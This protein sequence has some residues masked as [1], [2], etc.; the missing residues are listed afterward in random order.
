MSYED[1]QSQLESGDHD[2]YFDDRE[3]ALA[4]MLDVHPEELSAETYGGLYGEGETYTVDG[5]EY[6]VLT[7][8]ETESAV[9]EALD[10]YLDDCILCELPEIAQQYFDRDAWKRDAK[11]DGKGHILNSYDGGCEEI[12]VNGE[13]FDVYR[14]N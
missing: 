14:T 9:E 13:W 5:K 10:S 2:F 1:Y 4:E 12:K 11:S 8:L 3:L 6:A 7:E